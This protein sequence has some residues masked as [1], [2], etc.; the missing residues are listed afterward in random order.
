[1]VV[2]DTKSF[3]KFVHEEDVVVPFGT[4]AIVAVVVVEHGEAAVVE[5]AEIAGPDE[6]FFALFAEVDAVADMAVY[7]GVF[8][9]TLHGKVGYLAAAK[10]AKHLSRMCGRSPAD[11]WVDSCHSNHPVEHSGKGIDYFTG[12]AF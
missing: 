5:T 8:E 3:E 7:R 11:G 4:Q 9:G 6:F 12:V 10:E 2:G 1:M